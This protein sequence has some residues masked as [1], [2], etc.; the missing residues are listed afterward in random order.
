M[1]IENIYLNYLDS[2]KKTG[3][4]L[5]IFKLPTGIPAIF[6]SITLIIASLLQYYLPF[7]HI[8]F[9]LATIIC[10]DLRIVLEIRNRVLEACLGEETVFIMCLERDGGDPYF[11]EDPAYVTES[12]RKFFF[13]DAMFL[14]LRV[15]FIQRLKKHYSYLISIIAFYIA[16]QLILNFLIHQL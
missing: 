10:W 15:S 9:M 2:H 3:Y 5:G 4:I 13:K 11:P 7:F 1:D 6:I 16:T 8:Y 14:E 12:D